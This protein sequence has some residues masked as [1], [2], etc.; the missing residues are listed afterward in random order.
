MVKNWEDGLFGRIGI[1][2][3]VYDKIGEYDEMLL[4]RGGQDIDILNRLH[5]FDGG[6][7]ANLGAPEEA[8]ILNSMEDKI[9]EVQ[10]KHLENKDSFEVYKQLNRINLAISKFKL[11]FDGSGRTGGGFSYRDFLNGR[12]VTINGFNEIRYDSE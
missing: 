8:A 12:R 6:R 7:R 4:S 11:Q 1:S 5:V 2:K 3:I 9:A 10:S